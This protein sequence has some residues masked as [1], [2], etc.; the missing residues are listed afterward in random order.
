MCMLFRLEDSLNVIVDISLLI[1]T[2]QSLFS[3]SLIRENPASSIA[4]LWGNI[5]SLYQSHFMML[6]ICPLCLAPKVNEGPVFPCSLDSLFP[7][8]TS[9]LSHNTL[10]LEI[11]HNLTFLLISKPWFWQSIH[12]LGSRYHPKFE[13]HALHFALFS[14]LLWYDYF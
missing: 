14:F 8:R 7:G 6:R 4:L 11:R 5:P 9:V 10:S 1:A 12:M 13:N 2:E 3:N